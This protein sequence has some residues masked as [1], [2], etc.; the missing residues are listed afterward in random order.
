MN[1]EINYSQIHLFIYSF[2]ST[3]VKETIFICS[4]NEGVIFFTN[5]LRKIR[6]DFQRL[7]DSIE[8]RI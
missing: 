3:S 7:E 1:L 8:D 5:N 4:G 6:E 2:T